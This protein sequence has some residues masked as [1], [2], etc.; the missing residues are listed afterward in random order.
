MPIA[1]YDDGGAP[2]QM[3]VHCLHEQLTRVSIHVEGENGNTIPGSEQSNHNLQ[4]ELIQLELPIAPA[5][6]RRSVCFWALAIV[7]LDI[8]P[9]ERFEV[10]IDFKQG[11]NSMLDEPVTYSGALTRDELKAG[12]VA[13]L[14]R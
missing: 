13:F 9:N 6:L 1:R 5:D 4:D 8:D 2:I 10:K 12:S 3:L 7:A 14:P 11:E